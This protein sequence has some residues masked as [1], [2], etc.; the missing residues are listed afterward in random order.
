MSKAKTKFFCSQCGHE[1]SGWLGKCPGC[2]SWNTIVEEKF[3]KSSGKSAM[4]QS[5]WI[6]GSYGAENESSSFLLSDIDMEGETR[7]VTG[8]YELDRVLGGGFVKGSLVLVGGDPGIGKSTLLMQVCGKNS[9]DNSILYV[10]GEESP[11]QIRMRAQRLG[12]KADSIRVFAQTSFEAVSDEI[13]KQSP[14]I[15]IIDS[16]QTMYTS[17]VSSAPGSV[18]QV[19]E[20]AF[21]LLRIAKNTGT[22]IVLVGHVTKD[23]AIAGP[24]VLEHMV[25]T[26]LYFEGERQSS[27]RILRAVKNRFGATDE[28]GIFEMTEKGLVDVENASSAMLEGRPIGVPGTVVTSCMEGT[29]P[30]L[31]E[32]QSLL[33]PTSYAAPQRMTQGLD[34]S[35][36][37]MLLAVMDSRLSIGVSGM[38]A[39]IN[40]VGGIK[41]DETALDLAVVAAV[42]SC[43][44]QKPLKPGIIVFGEVGL[45]GEIRPVSNL[46]RRIN[47]ARRMGFS[48]CIL[49]GGSKKHTGRM[50]D[51]GNFELLYVDS[52]G[53]MIDVL[54]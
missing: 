46:D 41:S 11:K 45:T 7:F 53:E 22:T 51:Y 10:S 43:V 50:K 52:I 24:R 42:V 54:F 38:D 27:Y 1:T 35:R 39:F 5:G 34:R 9:N 31:I 49:P 36:I 26:V 19:R 47:E 18:S 8:I 2:G 6:D 17:E 14:Q 23:G 29:R 20:V 44:R 32:I 33:S 37:S 48:S 40:I 21:G 3:S 15:A 16:I 13:Q 30:I 12:V 4:S 25:D 28:I